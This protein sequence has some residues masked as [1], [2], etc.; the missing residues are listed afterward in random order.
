LRLSDQ[1]YAEFLK[2][3]LMERLQDRQRA[4]KITRDTKIRWAIGMRKH[5]L[6]RTTE[7]LQALLRRQEVIMEPVNRTG[8]KGALHEL[9][10]GSR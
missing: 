2:D 8:V 7:D 4:L 6:H 10:L 3:F 5:I 9:Y 1:G